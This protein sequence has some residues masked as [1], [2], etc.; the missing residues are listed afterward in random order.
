MR[1]GQRAAAVAVAG[2]AGVACG[3]AL[4][5]WLGSAP[6]VPGA[7]PA[8]A[9]GILA[10]FAVAFLG[11]LAAVGLAARYRPGSMRVLLYAG[12]LLAGGLAL[13]SCGGGPGGALL[14]PSGPAGGPVSVA[15]GLGAIIGVVAGVPAA[16]ALRSRLGGAW[17]SADAR[18][19]RWAVAALPAASRDRW[20]EEWSG[21]LSA[22]PSR[23]DRVRFGL[24]LLLGVPVLAWTLRA[25]SWRRRRG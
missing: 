20:H 5:A 24:S 16:F 13:V 22:L 17:R 14:G 19:L 15:A 4:P 12:A 2:A 7:L 10:G 1:R 23:R 9:F 18:L 25:A 6:A 3:A 21:E 11:A 8:A